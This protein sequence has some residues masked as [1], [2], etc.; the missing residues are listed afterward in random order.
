MP[1]YG[2][3]CRYIAAQYTSNNVSYTY[4]NHQDLSYKITSQSL[5]SI[6]N[7]IYNSREHIRYLTGTFTFSPSQEGDYSGIKE[8]NNFSIYLHS[9]QEVKSIV[10]AIIL[11]PLL[12]N[13]STKIDELKEIV[14][15]NNIPKSIQ[16]LEEKA[17]PFKN[18]SICFLNPCLY[19][20]H[21]TR[22]QSF[23]INQQTN[24]C[25]VNIVK[26]PDFLEN[27]DN[28]LSAFYKNLKM[29]KK[30]NSNLNIY[31]KN[32]KSTLIDLHNTIHTDISLDRYTL[33]R[34]NIVYDRV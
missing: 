32:I 11:V 3:K 34:N 22:A 25:L 29:P 6:N 15:E 17:T 18:L 28:N 4:C 26:Q 30:L 20:T 8:Q 10:K 19:A 14:N 16:L 23:Y 27:L 2:E 24:I 5:R 9:E 7:S 31:L 21:N 13:L 33:A 1:L 12:Y